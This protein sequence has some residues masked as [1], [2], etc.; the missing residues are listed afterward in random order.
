MQVGDLIRPSPHYRYKG[1]QWGEDVYIKSDAP[2]CVVT[3]IFKVG[4]KIVYVAF[5]CSWSNKT[6]MMEDPVN[7]KW[8]KVVS[9]NR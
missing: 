4:V 3:K 5:H 6:V 7:S 8:C 2:P 9:A 1:A